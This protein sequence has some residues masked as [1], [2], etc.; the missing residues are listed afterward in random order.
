MADN[1]EVFSSYT[2]EIKLVKEDELKDER[3]KFIVL[4]KNAL[5]LNDDETI[6]AMI[7]LKWNRNRYD[8]WRINQEEYKV[9][10]GIKLSNETKAD[11]EKKGIKSNGDRC[12]RCGRMRDNTFFSLNCGHQFCAECWTNYLK[13]KIRNPQEALRATCPQNGCTCIVYERLYEE[14]L[15]NLNDPEIQQHLAQFGIVIFSNFSQGDFFQRCP[16]ATCRYYAKSRI[17]SYIQ[18]VYCKCG[19]KFCFVCLKE[20]HSPCDCE[21]VKTFIDLHNSGHGNEIN[22]NF[23]TFYQRFLAF[24][25]SINTVENVFKNEFINIIPPLRDRIKV[26]KEDIDMMSEA[27]KFIIKVKMT[28]KYAVVFELFMRECNNK[29]LF[30][31][32]QAALE[33][34][35]EELYRL[36]LPSYLNPFI[37]ERNGE[38]LEEI[39]EDIE[40]RYKLLKDMRT[41]FISV[42]GNTYISDLDENLMNVNAH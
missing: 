24:D 12:L 9:R 19:K 15:R 10:A 21:L 28:L 42:A 39:R 22:Q 8:E 4:A 3:K 37:E 40:K 20:P 31:E 5:S 7:F 14:Y 38:R 6:L 1:L 26:L 29:R 33:R 34:E 41:K 16:N 35:T 11:L 32:S 18:E 27:F 23:D 25:E 36:L 30:K 13:E 2:N 17:N